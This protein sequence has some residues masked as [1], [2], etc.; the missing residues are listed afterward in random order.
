MGEID[1]TIIEMNR[2]KQKVISTE[3][4]RKFSRKKWQI[5]W[6]MGNKKFPI[7]HFCV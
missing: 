1:C 3:N 2:E 4:L 7:S 6:E 5:K